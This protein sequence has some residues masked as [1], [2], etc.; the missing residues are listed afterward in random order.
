MSAGLRL[1]FLPSFR[2]SPSSVSLSR[3]IIAWKAKSAPKKGRTDR[4]ADRLCPTIH[5]H[6][7]DTMS[8]SV[9]RRR[10]R[11]GASKR[12]TQMSLHRSACSLEKLDSCTLSGYLRQHSERRQDGSPGIFIPCLAIRKSSRIRRSGQCAVPKKAPQG[13]TVSGEM[14]KSRLRDTAF[15]RVLHPSGRGG[16]ASSRNRAGLCNKWCRKDD[17]IGR[18][19]PQETL[20]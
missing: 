4:P 3:P 10:R 12:R 16:G 2:P 5:S 1:S 8:G 19:N 6:T 9:G 7:K 18:P 14:V 15:S 11:E 20:R 13:T 17:I